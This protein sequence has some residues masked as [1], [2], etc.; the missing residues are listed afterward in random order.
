MNVYLINYE[1]L[2]ISNNVLDIT[3]VELFGL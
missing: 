3:A 1:C 2:P